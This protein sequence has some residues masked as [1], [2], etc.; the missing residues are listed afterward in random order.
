MYVIFTHIWLIFMYKCIYKLG[1]YTSPRGGG[2]FFWGGV[3]SVGSNSL[4]LHR[5]FHSYIGYADLPSAR[6]APTDICMPYSCF[7][8]F[9]P[10]PNDVKTM[11]LFGTA[12]N[13]ILNIY[14]YISI[15]RVYRY[16]NVNLGTYIH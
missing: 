2:E 1:K 7:V 6:V 12:M 13:L 5:K 10:P 4:F 8:N 16:I 11:F 14:I 9:C 15:P 3:V